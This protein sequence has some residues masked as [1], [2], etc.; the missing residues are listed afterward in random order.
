MYLPNLVKTSWIDNWVNIKH[1][2]VEFFLSREANCDIKA[3]QIVHSTLPVP[4][5]WATLKIKSCHYIKNEG[6]NSV[7]Y[8]YLYF[9]DGRGLTVSSAII[10]P[11]FFINFCAGIHCNSWSSL[12]WTAV[13]ECA[14]NPS[15]SQVKRW[16]QLCYHA[17]R[18]VT[19]VTVDVLKCTILR[20]FYPYHFTWYSLYTLV[21]LQLVLEELA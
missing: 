19:K 3:L 7:L 2:L 20:P 10:W 18:I 21:Y 17:A 15:Y 5:G 6:D 11:I 4:S 1:T 14:M 13:N 8:Q 12:G 16:K 9:C